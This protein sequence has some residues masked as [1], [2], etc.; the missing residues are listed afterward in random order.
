MLP[1]GLRALNK[2]EGV[3]DQEMA[4]VGGQKL[5][6]PLVLPKELWQ[7]TGRWEQTGAELFRLQDRHGGD[8]CLAPTHEEEITSL[9]ASAVSSYR[10]LPLRLYQTGA[11]KPEEKAAMSNVPHAITQLSLSFLLGRKYRD[12]VRPRFGLIRAREFVMKDMYTFDADERGAGETYEDVCR[13][14]KTIFERLELDVVM[15]RGLSCFAFSCFFPPYLVSF[16]P[17]SNATHAGPGGHG[18][19]RRE[20]VA[21]VSPRVQECAHSSFAYPLR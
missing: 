3:I 4:R 10:S 5:S 20:E 8:F 17:C 12:E 16:S 13:A 7:R 21:R 1:L 11:T 18:Q 15:V 6:L 19:H 2:L 9:V 14:Y